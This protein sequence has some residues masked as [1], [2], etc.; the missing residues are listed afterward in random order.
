MGQGAQLASAGLAIAF[1][2][3]ML[4]ASQ[5]FVEAQ[6]AKHLK[7]TIELRSLNKPIGGGFLR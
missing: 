1:A 4:V 7:G 6:S 2:A 3:L 5:L